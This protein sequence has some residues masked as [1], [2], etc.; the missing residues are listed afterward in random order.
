VQFHGSDFNEA[1]NANNGEGWQYSDRFNM[2]QVNDRA[3]NYP[4]PQS[5]ITM[6]DKST[7]PTA[8]AIRFALLDQ[9]QS[10]CGNFNSNDG[11][12]SANQNTKTNCGKLNS[13]PNRWPPI[14]LD[15]LMQM[16]SGTYYYVSTRNNN[17]SNRS[18]KNTIVVGPSSG[19]NVGAVVGGTLGALAALGIIVVGGLYYGK[20]H[21]NSKAGAC[22]TKLATSCRNCKS[23]AGGGSAYTRADTSM[24]A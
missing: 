23:R 16:N 17:F 3:T 24:K 2:V 7:N 9:T 20:K 5:Q 14:P 15:G 22:Y 21:P 4:L 18:Q 13:A 6:F 1:K 10:T 12:D 19:I 8:T 11:N